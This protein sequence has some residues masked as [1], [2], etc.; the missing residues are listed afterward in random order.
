MICLTGEA[1]VVDWED[2]L[3]RFSSYKGTI[4][5]FCKENNI[6]VHQFYYRRKKL[7]KMDTAM[8]HAI[9]FKENNAYKSINEE[10]VPS[11]SSS[12]S[13]IKIEIGK[14][15]ISIPGNDKISLSNILKVIMESC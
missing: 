11:S 15:K 2:I 3:D 10:T 14:A 6:S 8:F 7:K 12:S 4:R 9:S 1:S 13:V 5:A